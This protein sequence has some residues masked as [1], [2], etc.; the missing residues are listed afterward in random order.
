MKPEAA[1][2]LRKARTYLRRANNWLDTVHEGDEA[3]RVAYLA[4]FHAAQAFIFERAGKI[5]K[6]HRGVRSEFTRLA[7]QEP[8]LDG[9]F[10]QFLG[11]GY[12]RKE[13]VDY[14]TSSDEIVTEA[15]AREMIEAATAFVDQ[16]A[17]ILAK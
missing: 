17:A 10:T 9:S 13:A 12:Q 8:R 14:D 6:T 7:V 11:R 16:I 1:N 3:A 2:C 15:E 5:A 4:G